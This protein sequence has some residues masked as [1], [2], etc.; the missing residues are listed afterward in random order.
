MGRRFIGVVKTA[1]KRF[2]MKALAEK[3]LHTRGDRYGLVTM[4]GYK[5]ESLL[6]FVWMDRQRR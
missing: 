5:K 2:P 4:D 6:A 3:E 1:T